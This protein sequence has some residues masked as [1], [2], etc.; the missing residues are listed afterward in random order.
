MFLALK[1]P[2]SGSTDAFSELGQQNARPDVNIRL[3]SSVLHVTWQ[4]DYSFLLNPLLALTYKNLLDL[5]VT[6]WAKR[7]QTYWHVHK[8]DAH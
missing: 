4:S 3:Q 8:L 1:G 2:S 6:C 7:T 5:N